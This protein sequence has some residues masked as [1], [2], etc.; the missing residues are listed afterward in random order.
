[1]K[2]N[3]GAV[4]QEKPTQASAKVSFTKTIAKK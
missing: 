3:G 4:E 1:M 2:S